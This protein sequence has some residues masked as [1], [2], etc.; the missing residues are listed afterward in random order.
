ML[1]RVYT[2]VPAAGSGLRMG[3]GYSKAY[4]DV[5]G[6]PLLTNT[7]QALLASPF[8][9]EVTCAVRPDETGLCQK[10][11]VVKYGLAD[12]VTVIAGGLERQNTVEKLLDAI[13]NGK[14]IVLIHDGARP[15]V[16]V[17]LIEEVLTQTA[18]WGAAVVAV[19]VVDT[20]K[21]S[22][23]GGETVAKTVDRSILHLVQTPQAFHRDVITAAHRRARKEAWEITDDASAVER[24]GETVRI[25]MGD[26]MNI[27]IT[28]LEDLELCRWVLESRKL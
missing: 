20:V 23:D 26:P 14:D 16:S 24:M 3:L 8:I 12:E 18:Q 15:L 13:P 25:V 21:S 1:G 28:T 9:D 17:R 2:A 7:L 6:R 10:E 11:V 22:L 27:K 19:P 4:V 5:M